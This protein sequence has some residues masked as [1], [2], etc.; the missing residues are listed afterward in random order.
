MAKRNKTGGRQKGTPNRSTGEIRSLLSGILCKEIEKIPKHL[1]VIDPEKRL[2]ILI[3]LLPY[4]I[5][6]LSDKPEE[7]SIESSKDFIKLLNNQIK[8]KGLQ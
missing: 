2:Q 6:V 4:I 5:P 3:K 7:V 1:G 8:E